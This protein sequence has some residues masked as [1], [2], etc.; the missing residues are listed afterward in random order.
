MWEGPKLHKAPV[1]DYYHALHL[2]K[3]R[4]PITRDSSPFVERLSRQVAHAH[5]RLDNDHMMFDC[6]GDGGRITLAHMT[7]AARN[8]T[9]SSWLLYDTF[10][11]DSWASVS[12]SANGISN[13]RLEGPA[14]MTLLYNSE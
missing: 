8:V 14:S 3:L 13:L 1:L 11:T 2:I 7:T 5:V 6:L 12:P 4:L 9:E 10:E